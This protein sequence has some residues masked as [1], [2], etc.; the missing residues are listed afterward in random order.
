MLAALRGSRA[1][2]YRYAE[3]VLSL[4]EQAGLAQAWPAEPS[5]Q[6]VRRAARALWAWTRYVWQEVERRLGR[7]LLIQVDEAA[8]L[9]A[10]DRHSRRRASLPE[11]V[12][13]S[14][15]EESQWRIGTP[16]GEHLSRREEIA[17][18]RLP[19]LLCGKKYSLLSLIVAYH[20]WVVAK[21]GMM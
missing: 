2:N 10:V 11:D 16:P 4:E 1:Y 9:S 6:E 17:S 20:V 3:Q 18:L 21:K 12:I 14:G 8:L 7:S 15:S 13:L 19:G 5:Q